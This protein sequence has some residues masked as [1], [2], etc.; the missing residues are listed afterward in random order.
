MKYQANKI[1]DALPAPLY[2]S[3]QLNYDDE[4]GTMIIM[5]GKQC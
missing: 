5:I 3:P 1:F 2:C 4:G